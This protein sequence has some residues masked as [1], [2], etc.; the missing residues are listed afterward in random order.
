MNTIFKIP[1]FIFSFTGEP[2][3]NSNVDSDDDG[4]LTRFTV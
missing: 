2:I 4:E 3:I 1:L